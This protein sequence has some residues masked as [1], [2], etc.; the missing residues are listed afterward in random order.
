MGSDPRWRAPEEFLIVKGPDHVLMVWE[1][2]YFELT[3]Q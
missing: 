1:G 3:P 2:I